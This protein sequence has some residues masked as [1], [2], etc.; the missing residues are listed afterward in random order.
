MSCAVLVRP[1]VRPHDGGNF[2]SRNA[3]T[4]PRSRQLYQAEMFQHHETG[5]KQLVTVRET[6]V[7]PNTEDLRA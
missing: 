3:D 4:E 2:G 5:V 7:G 6:H 1:L